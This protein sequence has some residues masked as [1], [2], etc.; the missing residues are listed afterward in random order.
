M[1]AQ[2][3]LTKYTIEEIGITLKKVKELEKKGKNEEALNLGLRCIPMNPTRA[4]ILKQSVGLD[5]LIM[6]EVNLSEVV[7]EYGEEWL[8][9][10]R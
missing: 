5:Y 1:S 6:K 9:E 2:P 10:Y 8:E 7:E 4:E 3:N